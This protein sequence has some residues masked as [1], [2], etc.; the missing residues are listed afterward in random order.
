MTA[1]DMLSSP[2]VYLEKLAI[3]NFGLL[4]VVLLVIALLVLV[5]HVVS[6]VYYGRKHKKG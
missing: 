4:Q 2:A 6:L 1:N 3:S 5:A